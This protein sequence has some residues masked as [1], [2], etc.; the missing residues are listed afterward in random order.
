MQRISLFIGD[1]MKPMRGKSAPPTVNHD[2][3]SVMLWGRF[4]A[5]VTGGT[6]CIKGIMK[7]SGLSVGQRP[8][9]DIQQHKRM[10]GKEKAGLF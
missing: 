9:A 7:V 6:E 2:E 10:V 4:A 1:E 8:K 3:G 5:F